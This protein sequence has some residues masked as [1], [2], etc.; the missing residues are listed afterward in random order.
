M[1]VRSGNINYVDINIDSLGLLS[2]F[3]P[4]GLY[5]GHP[6]QPSINHRS[7][8]YGTFHNKA[9]DDSGLLVSPP[10]IESMV[11]P[12]D[13]QWFSTKENVS[14]FMYEVFDGCGKFTCQNLRSPQSMA[15]N[16]P[17]DERFSGS[18]IIANK[19]ARHI[20]NKCFRRLLAF[21]GYSWCMVDESGSKVDVPAEKKVTVN[22]ISAFFTL[23]G[24]YKCDTVKNFNIFLRD[25]DLH[26]WFSIDKSQSLETNIRHFFTLVQACTNARIGFFD[27][28]HRGFLCSYFATG[29]YSPWNRIDLKKQQFSSFEDNVCFASVSAEDVDKSQMQLFTKQIVSV[30]APDEKGTIEDQFKAMES[31]GV[32]RTNAQLLAVRDNLT[33]VTQEFLSYLDERE[34]FN[35]LKP[36]DYDNFWHPKKAHTALATNCN[37]LAANLIW[38][39]E[40][41]QKI[42]FLNGSTKDWEATKEEIKTK[43]TSLGWITDLNERQNPGKLGKDLACLVMFAKYL[44]NDP[45]GINSLRQY[46]DKAT[47][48]VPQTLIS[49]DDVDFFY[50]Q[51]FMKGVLMYKICVAA[52]H[53]ANKVLIEKKLIH[54][55]RTSKQDTARA[56]DL[57]TWPYFYEMQKSPHVDF[58]GV[59]FKSDEIFEKISDSCLKLS[60]DSVKLGN[61][62][63]YAIY[64]LLFVDAME[65]IVNYGLNP[66]FK[67]MPN[68]TPKNILVSL[69]LK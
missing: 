38:F 28:K 2:M 68:D 50:T 20:T 18:G 40:L 16:F 51:S 36:L 6:Y 43:M 69:F 15:I 12:T 8:I 21:F 34:I 41:K 66:K 54:I 22:D 63:E 48:R 13:E 7:T 35:S 47:A 9:Y 19:H 24:V 67:D 61:K 46:L 44:F 59:T 37:T 4:R 17:D 32:R 3:V 57:E 14:I 64:H 33:S 5:S 49:R 45:R 29:Y 65:T 42:V 62:L 58:A 26:G 30:G 52:N 27:G 31:F 23:I 1:T 55:F 11:K 53:L 10:L 39:I 56:L 60:S 25:H